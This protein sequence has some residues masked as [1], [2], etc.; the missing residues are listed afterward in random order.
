MDVEQITEEL[1]GLKPGEFVAARDAYVAEARRAKD[2]V[3]AKEIAALRKPA[4]AAW[5]ANRLARERRQEAQR[6]LTLGERLREAHRT[7][8]AEQLRA[9]SREQHRLVTALARTAAELAREVGQP[10]SETVV[11][12][13][14]QTLHGV[15]AHED[16]AEL[17][18]RGRLTKVPEAAVGFTAVAPEETALAQAPAGQRPEPEPKLE[19]EPKHK[20]K[21]KPTNEP[22]REATRRRDLERAR[23]AAAEADAEVARREQELEEGQ[24][25]LQA[26]TT[27]AEEAA[28]EV[29]RLETGL[30]EARQTRLDSQRAESTAGK[31]VTTAERDLQ[32]ARRAAERAARTVERLEQG[33]A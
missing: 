31:A 17:W 11:H 29:G 25:L 32:Q 33:G 12:E 30:R 28:A 27:E 21:P 19:S 7:L 1:Y 2:G 6:F 4:L 15:L 5:A 26:A 10:V 22:D 24:R 18:S 8:D 13:V 16:V 20:P 9:A 23:A 14:E 3:A